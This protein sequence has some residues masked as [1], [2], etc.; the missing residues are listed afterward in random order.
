MEMIYKIVP[1]SLWHEAKNSGCL[2]GTEADLA[3]GFIHFSTSE[4]ICETAEKYFAGQDGLILVAAE[5]NRLGGAL[6]FEPSRDGALFPHLY[7]T[8]QLDA[9]VWA[10]PLRLLPNGKHDF[11]GLFA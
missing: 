2:A 6:R 7:G 11:A 10:K 1:A 8:L 9:V 4:Q 5:K 3:D